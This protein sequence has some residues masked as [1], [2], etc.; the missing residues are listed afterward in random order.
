MEWLSVPPSA[1]FHGKAREESSVCN[2]RKHIGLQQAFGHK[3]LLAPAP[4]V[5][6]HY[7]I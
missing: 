4:Q 3:Q 6:Q 2:D 5:Y 1:Q 7:Y